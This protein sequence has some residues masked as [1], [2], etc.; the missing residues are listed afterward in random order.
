MNNPSRLLFIVLGTTILSF[1]SCVPKKHLLEA[2]GRINSL[3]NKNAELK[4]DISSLQNRLKLMEEA[5]E[6]AANDLESQ[7]KTIAANQEALKQ[8]EEKLR[9]LQSLIDKQKQ[10]TEALRQK[11]ANA[12][13]NFSS[14]QL[15]V[16]T[17]NG[18]VYVSMSEKLLF[19]SG[20][21]VVNKDGK[22]ALAQIAQAI[23]E[24]ADINI[25]I[26][27]HTD[28][29]PIKFRFEDNWAL[30]VARSTAI[31]RVLTKDYSVAPERITASGKSQYEPI[32]D[33]TTA[34]GRAHNR[35]TEIILAPKLDKL[36]QL[37]EE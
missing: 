25:N 32:A 29:V 19:P 23:N 8:K 27:G 31:L 17:K 22:E 33:N 15:S 36:M 6:S 28:T 2:E 5:N 3:Q 18:K 37:I 14:D 11:M 16:F 13:V 34:E 24:N 1:S 30:S 21:A 26:E 12:L 20:S 10:Q 35:R 7:N 4:D 9:E